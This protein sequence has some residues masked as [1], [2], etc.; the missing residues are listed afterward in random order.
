MVNVEKLSESRVKLTIEVTAEQFETCLDKAFEKVV[1]EV[2]VDGFRPGKLPKKQFID[3]FGYE[4]LYEDAINFAFQM[5]Y[6]AAV[7][8]AKVYPVDNP[9]VNIAPDSKIEKG[10]G[11]SYTAEVDVWPEV[12]LGEYKGLKVKKAAVRVLK[13]DI[14]EYIEKALK[15]K[16]ENV[17][18]DG[19]AE[20][21]D[22]VVMDFVGSID[23]VEFEGGKGEN[24]SLE[25]GSNSFIPGFEDQLVGATSETNID[26]NVSFPE[27]YQAKDLAG[28]PALFK[29]LVHEVKTKVVPTLTNEFVEEL[30]IE[31]VK[32]VEEYN[33][34]V[35]KTLK[36]QREK[37]NEKKFEEECIKA[38]TD[39]AYAEFPDSL[40]K[41]AVD[42]DV[43]NVTSQAKQYNLPVEVL[44]QYYGMASLEDFK[45]KAEKQIRDEYLKELCFE[46]IAELENIQVSEEEVNAKYLEAASGDEKKANELKKQYHP[47]QVMYSI[48]VEKV[49]T[50]IKES[51]EK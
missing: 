29:C 10:S 41:R 2:K 21:G 36:E 46:K 5:T 34:Y 4:S 45:T 9:N 33:D 43:E 15:E 17:V 1:K 39:A 16:S 24:Y 50:L 25:L 30:E 8:E 28:K 26:V 48:K 14:E 20:L 3:R 31:G 6:D 27:D 12:H 51:V 35:K 38:V 32:T 47:S 40:I 11:F 44:L 18:K 13:K 19:P 42:K 23:G 49:I 37:E 7:E 22:T